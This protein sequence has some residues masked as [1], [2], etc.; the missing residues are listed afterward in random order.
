MSDKT[1]LPYHR[2]G[3]RHHGYHVLSTRDD[4]HQQLQLQ[5]L[6]EQAEQKQ[7]LQD[8]VFHN[9]L[10]T[11]RDLQ[12]RVAEWKPRRDTT[13][14]LLREIK[15]LLEKSYQKRTIAKVSGASAAI[16]GSTLAIVGFGLSFFTF[17]ASLGLTVAGGILAASGG[18]TMGGADLGDWIVSRSHMK[19]VEKAIEQDRESSSEL[20][21]IAERFSNQ[22]S[23]LKIKYP[24]VKEE[25][26][27]TAISN[28][29]KGNIIRRMYSVP[30]A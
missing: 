23:E 2:H 19:V 25:A 21:E 6:N 5:Q 3:R 17:G 16:T 1:P 8:P 11:A 18:V 15:D 7:L 30:L 14:A 20:R 22:I 10:M 29:I 13:L 27:L 9:A 4:D 24:S 12:Q 28:L 26:I